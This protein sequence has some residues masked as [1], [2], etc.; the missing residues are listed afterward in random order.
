MEDKNWHV[1]M[2]LG[3]TYEFISEEHP[4]VTIRVIARSE[5]EA[6]EKLSQ[7]K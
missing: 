5:E 6:R 2:D 3:F 4:S 7:L 1:D